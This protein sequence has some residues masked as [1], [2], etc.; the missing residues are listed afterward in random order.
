MCAALFLCIDDMLRLCRAKSSFV[1]RSRLNKYIFINLWHFFPFLSLTLSIS[2]CRFIHGEASTNWNYSKN[3]ICELHPRKET[4][5]LHCFFSSINENENTDL[6]ENK[7][8]VYQTHKTQKKNFYMDFDFDII[9]S[10][11]TL[12]F[13]FYHFAVVFKSVHHFY[14]IFLPLRARRTESFRFCIFRQ[15]ANTKWL[16]Y[17]CFTSAI[18]LGFIYFFSSS[19]TL[20]GY[21]RIVVTVNTEHDLCIETQTSL[22]KKHYF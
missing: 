12:S 6:N 9:P 7:Q 19:F 4:T 8:I 18:Y 3:P 17:K 11:F 20:L 16:I 21:I 22:K 1:F 14:F 13:L 10:Y 15:R 2:L 5:K